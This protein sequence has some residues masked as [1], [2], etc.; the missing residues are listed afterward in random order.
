[1]INSQSSIKHS[2]IAL[3]CA[4]LFVGRADAQSVKWFKKAR[5]AQLNIVTYD[6]NGQLLNTTNGFFIDDEGTEAQHM[7]AWGETGSSSLKADI[8]VVADGGTHL[9]GEP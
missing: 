8:A 1:M 6:A 4:F 2:I 5:K 7:A 3:C 9:L